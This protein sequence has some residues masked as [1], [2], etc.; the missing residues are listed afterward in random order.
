MNGCL[1]FS[2]IKSW[3]M[4]TL[5]TSNIISLWCLCSSPIKPTKD[6]FEVTWDLSKTDV[7]N[8]LVLKLKIKKISE[9]NKFLYHFLFLRARWQVKKLCSIRLEPATA[10]KKWNFLVINRLQQSF[11][12]LVYCLLQACSLNF[13]SLQHDVMG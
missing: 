8:W 13:K 6:R 12:K 1:L 9:Y 5:T 2:T 10:S 11:L 7:W 4:R 3:P